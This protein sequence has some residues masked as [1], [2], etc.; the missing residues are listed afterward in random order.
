MLVVYG[1]RF[2]VVQAFDRHKIFPISP[3]RIDYSFY[4]EQISF[5]SR[6]LRFSSQVNQQQTKFY[7]L[8]LPQFALQLT[9]IYSSQAQSPAFLLNPRSNFAL[10]INVL[11]LQS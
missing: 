9:N 10:Y 1:L 7:F 4:E 11:Q 8:Y 5:Q 3:A 6:L 2:L